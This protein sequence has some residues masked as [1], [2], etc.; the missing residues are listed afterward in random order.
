[1]LSELAITLELAKQS[2]INQPK[3]TPREMNNPANI[4]VIENDISGCE[5]TDE[6][7]INGEI[8]S[9]LPVSKYGVVACTKMEGKGASTGKLIIQLRNGYRING[10]QLTEMLLEGVGARENIAYG[11]T[12]D[13]FRAHEQPLMHDHNYYTT[14]Q[15][16]VMYFDI[17][18]NIVNIRYNLDKQV[19]I[20][21][22]DLVRLIDKCTYSNEQLGINPNEKSN[23]SSNIDPEV[24]SILIAVFCFLL[25]AKSIMELGIDGKLPKVKSPRL[26][27]VS[28]PKA[29]DLA[30]ITNRFKRS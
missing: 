3:V 1:M 22:W 19:S 18:N 28:L 25:G 5:L 29:S 13:E 11:Y 17:E 15:G 26:P 14:D 27:K 23:I 30:T 16:V 10:T 21:Y 20:N 12:E 7:L 6:E 9:F 2:I 4:L 24:A 8:L